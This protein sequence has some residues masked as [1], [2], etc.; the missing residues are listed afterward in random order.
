MGP[1]VNPFSRK[2]KDKELFPEDSETEI[3]PITW[4]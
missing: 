3:V 1:I 4:E 2:I